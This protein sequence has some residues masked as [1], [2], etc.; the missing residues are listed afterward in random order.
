MHFPQ[1]IVL[2]SQMGPKA[3]N[4][5]VAKP[6][7]YGY[8]AEDILV[9]MLRLCLRLAASS[10]AFMPALAADPDFS[11]S[12]CTATVQRMATSDR[13]TEARHVAPRFD[14]LLRQVRCPARP[15]DGMGQT[16]PLLARRAS[17]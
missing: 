12:L 7:Q 10:S 6:E 13:N 8:D 11:H 2:A 3:A 16:H 17:S 5:N 9:R 15:C 1:T 4:L 14:D